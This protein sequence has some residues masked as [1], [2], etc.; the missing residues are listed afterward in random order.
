LMIL[1]FEY[2]PRPLPATRIPTPEYIRILKDLPGTDGVV[3]VITG[4]TVKLYFQTIHEKPIASGYVS[5]IPKSS[6]EMDTALLELIQNGE[7]ERAYLDYNIRYLLSESVPK[8]I[9][10]VKSLKTLYNDGKVGLF[11]MAPST[12]E[13]IKIEGPDWRQMIRVSGGLMFI[14]TINGQ[15]YGQL[16]NKAIIDPVKHKLLKIDGWAVDDHRKDSGQSVYL[17]F[18]YGGEEIIIPTKRKRRPDVEKHF[19]VESYTESG[20]TSSVKTERFNKC[21]YNLSVRILRAG[22][23]EYYELDGEKPVCFGIKP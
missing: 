18:R 7:F 1:F 16:K 22:R 12:R 2:L 20:W 15:L 17:V 23:N 11:D 13:L 10:G 14:D 5:R 21:C 9:G 3:D 19:K 8:N 4:P 6:S